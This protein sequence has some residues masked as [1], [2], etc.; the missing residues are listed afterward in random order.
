[1]AGMAGRRVGM[2]TA[3]RVETA[4]KP[5]LYGDGGNLYL[6]VDDGGSKSWIVRLRSAARSASTASAR[7]HTVT[8][9][10]ARREGRDDP[11]AVARRHRPAGSPARQAGSSGSRAAKS[12]SFDKAR[13]A[14]IDE[15][16][17]RMEVRQARRPVAGDARR[18]TPRPYSA[19]CR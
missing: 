3:R 16:P 17:R 4:R 8:L 11:Q 9:S 13:T 18:P 1:M 14:Y 19:S 10:E 7:S 15:P 6:K 2:L 5:G 12:I